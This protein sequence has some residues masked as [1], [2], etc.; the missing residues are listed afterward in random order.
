MQKKEDDWHVVLSDFGFAKEADHQSS[1]YGGHGSLPYMAPEAY[2]EI[3]EK[4]KPCDVY[5]LGMTLWAIV[6]RK[7]PFDHFNEAQMRQAYMNNEKPTFDNAVCTFE[8]KKIILRC[9]DVEPDARPSAQQVVEDL[10]R[11]SVV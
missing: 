11:K 6:H 5:S 2:N 7:L 8:I 10:D 1:R 3:P 9:I 4:N